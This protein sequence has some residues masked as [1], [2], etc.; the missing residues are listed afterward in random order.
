MV[1]EAIRRKLIE[2]GIY[3][4]HTPCVATGY[5]R[6][7]DPYADKTVT[8]ITCHAKGACEIF[9]CREMT[10]IDIGGQDTKI[11]RIERQSK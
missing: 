11:I 6:A 1:S 10:V 4:L 3:A 9:S 5:G 7:A 8:E 2:N